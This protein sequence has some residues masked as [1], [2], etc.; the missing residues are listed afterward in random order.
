MKVEKKFVTS[1]LGTPLYVQGSDTTRKC[2]INKE[3]KL[4]CKEN[5]ICDNK[6]NFTEASKKA[7]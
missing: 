7:E 6:D 3:I 4:E 5:N 2:N 1:N